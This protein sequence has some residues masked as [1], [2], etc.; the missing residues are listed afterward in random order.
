MSQ[1]L[2]VTLPPNLQLW[3]GCVI[4]VT[5]LNPTTGAVVSGVNV[6]NITIEADQLEGSESDLAVGPFMLVTGPGG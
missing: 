3:E 6:K 4:R 2:I 1:P 5:A